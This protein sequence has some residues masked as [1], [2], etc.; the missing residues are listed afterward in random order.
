MAAYGMLWLACQLAKHAYARRRL[1]LGLRWYRSQLLRVC[2]SV[3][4]GPQAPES[5]VAVLVTVSSVISKL[6]KGEGVVGNSGKLGNSPD[7]NCL[8]GG[9]LACKTAMTVL[10]TLPVSEDGC[11][12]LNFSVL[13]VLVIVIAD[14]YL[15]IVVA[16]ELA[17]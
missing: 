4:P 6:E 10:V 3:P 11:N 13:L 16:L 8:G 12:T 1:V 7:C 14:L 2:P 9:C 15:V 17:S 5:L